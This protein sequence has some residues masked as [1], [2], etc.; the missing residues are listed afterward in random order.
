MTSIC[1]RLRPVKASTFWVAGAGPMPMMRGSTPTLAMPTTRAFGVRPCLAALAS[2]ASNNAQAPSFT[3]E[4]LPA[5]TVPSG[6]TM[7]LS[8]ASASRL[9]SRGCSSWLTS[10][11]SPYFWAM[12]TGVISASRHAFFCAISALRCE[13][14]AIWSCASR[15][16]PKSAATFSAVSGM[17]STP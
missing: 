6:R 16:M 11:A 5:V 17:L 3:P 9:V 2:S 12:L 7:P 15:E 10:S 13:R 1:A 4:A 14:Q 8:L